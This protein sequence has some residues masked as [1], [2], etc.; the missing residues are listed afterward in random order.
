MSLPLSVPDAIASRHAIRRYTDAPVPDSD[1]ERLATL[2]GLAPSAW[3]VQPCRL[4]AVRDPEVK[5]KLQQ[6]AYGQPQVGS[7]PVVWVVY[8]DM[9]AALEALESTVHPGMPPE[10]QAAQNAQVRGI[11]GKQPEAQREGWG[12][13]QSN[14][15]LGFLLLAAE[16]LGYATS[17]MLGFD[18]AAVKALF[19]IPEHATVAALVAMGVP[20][21]EGF[22][23]H[24]LPLGELLRVI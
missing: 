16:S 19:G 10:R 8:S 12:N 6:A 20:A 7:A 24:R 2:A 15:A 1:V 22:P 5:D 4:V 3:N 21:E 18:P 9:V 17:P 11:F 13:A 23:H 14:I